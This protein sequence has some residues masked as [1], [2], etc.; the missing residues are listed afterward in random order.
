[1]G[2]NQ[3]NPGAGGGLPGQGG[4]DKKG[5]Q[6]KQDHQIGC[7]EKQGHL[8]LRLMVVIEDRVVFYRFKLR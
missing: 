7:V 1:M 4:G 5:D 3:S 6:V 8:E 2:N